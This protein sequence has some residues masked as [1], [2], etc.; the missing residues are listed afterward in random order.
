MNRAGYRLAVVRQPCQNR[1]ETFVEGGIEAV[2]V[3]DQGR[4]VA[5]HP[6]PAASVG[7]GHKHLAAGLAAIQ[8]WPIIDSVR[9]LHKVHFPDIAV[10]QRPPADVLHVRQRKLAI[11]GQLH[12]PF[13]ICQAT[14]SRQHTNGQQPNMKHQ[15]A[16]ITIDA[17][18]GQD[19]GKQIQRQQPH[20]HRQH[21]CRRRHGIIVVQP[22]AR[23]QSG[24]TQ[25]G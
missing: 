10:M 25:Q 22:R 11:P 20:G 3:D 9:A 19:G 2:T 12:P 16:G 23:R 18:A 14:N 5:N 4:I 17:G 24:H 21:P 13:E 6:F 8:T 7:I 1:C 15:Q